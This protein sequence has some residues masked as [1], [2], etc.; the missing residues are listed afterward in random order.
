M[1]R[2]SSETTLDTA[3]G[4]DGCVS[5]HVTWLSLLCMRGMA[6]GAVCEKGHDTHTLV[7]GLDA[8]EA[9]ACRRA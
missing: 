8:G 2:V 9:A 6:A 1:S 3:E 7:A 5:V 4:G